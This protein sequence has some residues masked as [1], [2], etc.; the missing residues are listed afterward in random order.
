VQGVTRG[1][2]SLFADAVGYAAERAFGWSYVPDRNSLPAGH[3]LEKAHGLDVI[4]LNDAKPSSFGSAKGFLGATDPHR[5][6]YTDERYESG[7]A[8][9][10]H[11]LTMT[12][13]R[14]IIKALGPMFYDEGEDVSQVLGRVSRAFVMLEGDLFG[15]YGWS[16]LRSEPCH[17][18]TVGFQRRN[19]HTD[20]METVV[21]DNV[22]YR[23]DPVHAPDGEVIVHT[24]VGALEE[25][26]LA[27]D[28]NNG[29]PLAG[30]DHA[31]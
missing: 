7:A 8:L 28:A 18:R 21:Q 17:P 31:Y 2:K 3:S 15:T 9:V 24:V 6:T 20:D 14:T 25:A 30:L 22:I 10:Y 5:A 23:L 27:L 16:V 12:D 11:S 19:A 13:T 1:G 4:S 26:L 29:Y